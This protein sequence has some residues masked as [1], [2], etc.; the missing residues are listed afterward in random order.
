[1]RMSDIKV[2]ME[3]KHIGDSNIRRI[4]TVTELTDK[5]FR[6]TTPFYYQKIGYSNGVPEFGTV[7][8][9]EYYGVDGESY[10][11]EVL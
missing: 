10:L 6:Y 4:L 8:S 9:G 7:T 2:G 11:E 1:M 5:G 3:L